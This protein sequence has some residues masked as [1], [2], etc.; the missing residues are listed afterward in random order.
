MWN[1]WDINPMAP[2]FRSAKVTASNL[3]PHGEKGNYTAEILLEDFPQF[4]KSTTDGEGNT[5][6]TSL[7]PDGI[8]QTFLGQVNDSVLPSR[9]GSMWRYAAGLYVAHFASL[10][11]KTYAP[12]SG[13]TG[14]VSS[15]AQQMGTVKAATMGDTTISYD[16]TAITAG[17]EKWGAW[18]ATIYG[19]Q[20]VTL[21]RQVG[22]GG[23]YVI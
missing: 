12:S 13:N 22:M 17:I 4:S 11:L 2:Y 5:T 18:N 14:Q 10:Y 23:M 3:P 16:N 6:V 21:A 15:K 1:G 19:Q 7:I 9:W 20:L 8:M